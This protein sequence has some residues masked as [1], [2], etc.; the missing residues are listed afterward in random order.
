LGT[1]C[2]YLFENSVKNVSI[3]DGV[4]DDGRS[5]R[6]YVV[7]LQ[8][9]RE[10]PNGSCSAFQQGAENAKRSTDFISQVETTAAAK[11]AI[12]KVVF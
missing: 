4:R 5:L 9:Q 8:E 7:F 3:D 10:A 12:L 1:F 6:S 2:I 11:S